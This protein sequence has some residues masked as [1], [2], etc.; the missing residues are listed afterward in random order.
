M[1]YHSAWYWK[2]LTESSLSEFNCFRVFPRPG[3]NSVQS[4]LLLPL[5][6][7]FLDRFNFWKVFIIQYQM[8]R[9]LGFSLPLSYTDI[10]C[11]VQSRPLSPSHWHLL[12]FLYSHPVSWH[13][14]CT[15]LCYNVLSSWPQIPS[16]SV[17]FLFLSQVS[18]YQWQ[19]KSC[20]FL[21]LLRGRRRLAMAA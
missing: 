13:T 12:R 4:E 18:C 8:V 6:P 7:F 5:L 21:L 20:C 14:S 2:M 9:H 10:C 19:R 3:F 17:C 1:S 16:T 11:N 15:A